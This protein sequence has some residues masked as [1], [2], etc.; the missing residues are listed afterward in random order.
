MLDTR[1]IVFIYVNMQVSVGSDDK[2]TCTCRRIG[3]GWFA[4]LQWVFSS[5]DNR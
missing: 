1:K 3:S 4:Q 2:G 5:I